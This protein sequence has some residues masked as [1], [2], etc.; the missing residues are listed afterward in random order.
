MRG[1]ES[2]RTGGTP[3][4]SISAQ[5]NSQTPVA[6]GGEAGRRG[7]SAGAVLLEPAQL[8]TQRL[9]HQRALLEDERQQHAQP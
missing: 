9:S 5:S 2:E 6:H 7:D 4:Y 1:L 8:V 3:T